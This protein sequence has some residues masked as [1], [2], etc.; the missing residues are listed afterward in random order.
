M[1]AT[2]QRLVDEHLSAY[3]EPDA[4]KRIEAVRRIWHPGGRLVDPP[5]ESAGHAGIAEQGGLLLQQFPGHRFVRHT[6]VDAH[7]EFLRYGWQLVSPEGQPVL[8]GLDLMEL[9]VDGRICRVVGFF[10]PQ[11]AAAG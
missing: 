2:A 10:G 8:E 5:L 3:C 1:T 7:H 6:A 4:G 11:P 9:D